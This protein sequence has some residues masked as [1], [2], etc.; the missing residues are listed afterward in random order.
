MQVFI[1]N[2]KMKKTYDVICESVTFMRQNKLIKQIQ[3]I[4][5]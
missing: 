2:W 4:S 5:R 1:D 3:F